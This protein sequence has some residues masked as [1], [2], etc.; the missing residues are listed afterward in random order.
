M[1]LSRASDLIAAKHAALITLLGDPRG[2]VKQAQGGF[3]REFE[4]GSIF[5]KPGSQFSNPPKPDIV[6]EVHGAI[7]ERWAALGW[8]KSI[9]KFPVSDET[10]TPDGVGRFNNFERGC[11]Y[12]HPSTGAFEVHGDILKKWRSMGTERSILGYPLSDEVILQDLTGRVSH[13]QGGSIYWHPAIGACEVHGAI[14]ERWFALGAQLSFL[15]YPVSDEGPDSTGMGRVSHF[16]HG[17]IHWSSR[18]GIRV[19]T[20]RQTVLHIRGIKCNSVST[21]LDGQYFEAVNDVLKVVKDPIVEGLKATGDPTAIAVA[22]VFK[23]AAELYGAVPGLLTKIDAITG[24]V[25][26]LFISRSS[27]EPDA[28]HQKVWPSGDHEDMRKGEE[29]LY[30]DVQIPFRDFAELYFWEA[31]RGFGSSPDDALGTLRVDLGAGAG[32]DRMLGQ[33]IG[34]PHEGSLYTVAYTIEFG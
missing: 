1:S 12:W 11:I 17:A 4:R 28:E 14:R 15:G 24:D 22:Q 18:H 32:P 3:F 7:R 21:G 30:L 19:T 6:C 10:A 16:E 25:D 23:V 29:R 13:F 2:E 27:H 26:Q 31:D 5:C 8:E 34:N 9:L 20:H 33:V